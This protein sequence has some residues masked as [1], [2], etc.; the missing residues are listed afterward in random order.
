MASKNS[1]Q[2]IILEK[3]CSID[4]VADLTQKIRVALSKSNAIEFDL[5][6]V[7]ELELPVI[8]VLY[9]AALSADSRGGSAN[10]AGV[11][12]ESVASR[13]LVTGFSKAAVRDG[14][15]LQSGLHGFSGAG[16]HA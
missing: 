9:A 16:A 3:T 8:Q 4:G 7:T 5:S 13:L 6:E 10:L 14:Q 11:I 1:V 12:Q 15:G 2:R